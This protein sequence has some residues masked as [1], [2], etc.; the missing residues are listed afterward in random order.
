MK[1]FSAAFRVSR[2]EEVRSEA[3]AGSFESVLI[4]VP[5]P[6][7]LPDII[8]TQSDSV[9]LQ[10]QASFARRGVASRSILLAANLYSTG[11][12]ATFE[13]HEGLIEA[14]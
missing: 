7:G 1:R 11:L 8:V 14:A 10:N 12:P 9:S 6:N 4:G 2:A 13:N 3:I 5:P